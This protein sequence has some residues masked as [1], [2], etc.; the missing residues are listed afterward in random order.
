[1]EV[2]VQAGVGRVVK[3]L[4]VETTSPFPKGE[5]PGAPMENQVM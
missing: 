1:M 4:V 2:I 3:I 5:A